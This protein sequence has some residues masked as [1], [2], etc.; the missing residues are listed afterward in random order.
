M[1]SITFPKE[2]VVAEKELFAIKQA[3]IGDVKGYIDDGFPGAEKDEYVVFLKQ[4]RRESRRDIDKVSPAYLRI[5][6]KRS[7]T[8]FTI[9]RA[10]QNIEQVREAT[11]WIYDRLRLLAPV[12]TGEYR[13]NVQ[14]AA[15][16]AAGA[17]ITQE[18]RVSYSGVSS[19]ELS[20]RGYFQVYSTAQHSVFLEAG[21]YTGWMKNRQYK[22]RGL[23]Y[24]LAK[25]ARAMFPDISIRFRFVE[26]TV[27][28]WMLP[29]IQIGF[30]GVFSANEMDARPGKHNLRRR[31]AALKRRYG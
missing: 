4:G 15:N 11:R 8:R 10:T 31:A 30:V 13:R 28:R 18:R 22:N 14:I 25:D 24:Q 26:S 3:I 20:R 1:A 9:R 17:G 7:P 6:T 19:V 23:M 12:K 5:G 27:E 2:A 16:V 29:A 21:Y